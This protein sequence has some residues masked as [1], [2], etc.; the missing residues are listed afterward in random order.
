[1]PIAGGQVMGD[2]NCSDPDAVNSID[3]LLILRANA[4]LST[5]IPLGCPSIKP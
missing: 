4:G 3:A 2:V 1:L 5:N